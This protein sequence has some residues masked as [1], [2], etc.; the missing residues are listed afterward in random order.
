MSPFRLYA[1]EHLRGLWREVGLH[2]IAAQGYALNVAYEFFDYTNLGDADF[3]YT[4][5]K[6]ETELLR[7]RSVD[8]LRLYVA[9][10]IALEGK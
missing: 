2:H 5:V 3:T 9:A 10:M 1:K 4:L 8:E 6:N 7:T